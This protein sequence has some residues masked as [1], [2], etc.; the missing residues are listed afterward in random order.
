MVCSGEIKALDA[1]N[2]CTVMPQDLGTC[3]IQCL[4][5]PNAFTPL[6]SDRRYSA[7]DWVKLRADAEE[8]LYIMRNQVP[9]NCRAEGSVN[10]KARRIVEFH[11]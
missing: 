8:L 7:Q 9:A 1:A 5:F 6:E 10:G 4:V 3:A 11:T 2:T